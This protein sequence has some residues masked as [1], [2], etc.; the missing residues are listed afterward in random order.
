MTVLNIQYISLHKSSRLEGISVA[1][2]VMQTV[3]SL[4]ESTYNKTNAQVNTNV[5]GLNSWL[6]DGSVET[7]QLWKH[8]QTTRIKNKL[9]IITT[10]Y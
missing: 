6:L 2:R 1:T 7:L 3:C 9:P 10:T 4:A 5:Y 8:L